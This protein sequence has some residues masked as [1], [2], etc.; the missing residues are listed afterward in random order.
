[1]GSKSRAGRRGQ[2]SYHALV[3]ATAELLQEHDDDN[4]EDTE[5]A[6]SSPVVAAFYE[7]PVLPERDGC[8]S[9]CSMSSLNP[10]AATYTFRSGERWDL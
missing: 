8:S 9:Y 6:G 5:P 3:P 4:L 1:M 2:E 10:F 7:K